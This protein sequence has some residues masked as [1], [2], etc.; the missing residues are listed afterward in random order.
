MQYLIMIY[1]DALGFAKRSSPE[2]P[3]HFGAYRAYS[4]AL[5]EAGVREDQDAAA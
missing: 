5:R 3:K 1:E 4:D 2:A